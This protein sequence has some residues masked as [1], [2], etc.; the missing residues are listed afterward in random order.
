PSSSSLGPAAAS[1]LGPVAASSLGPVAASSAGA[2]W[3]FSA[4]PSLP[5]RPG[6]WAR[7][8]NGGSCST[9]SSTRLPLRHTV[10]GFFSGH[11]KDGVTTVPGA[12]R[13]R[14][15]SSKQYRRGS[16][17][18]SRASPGLSLRTSSGSAAS[19]KSSPGSLQLTGLGAFAFLSSLAGGSSS[20][21]RSRG[22]PT[23]RTGDGPSFTIASVQGSPA[24]RSTISSRRPR[25]ALLAG[26]SLFGA[27]APVAASSSSSAR[28]G[29]SGGASSSE[30]S[31]ALVAS[32]ASAGS[33]PALSSAVSGAFAERWQ[34]A[35]VAR[36]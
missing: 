15:S 23:T 31:S 7:A 36:I 22:S 16:K 11:P 5:G 17:A 3:S 1:S 14:A 21:L 9:G 2:S 34:A 24:P 26:A 20:R 32:S 27:R 25:G 8:T 35:P 19:G 4:S 12:S 30:T 29:S 10:F 33:L 18:W 6:P 28:S 13:S